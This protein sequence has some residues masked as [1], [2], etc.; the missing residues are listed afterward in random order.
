MQAAGLGITLTSAS[1]MLFAELSWVAKDLRQSEDR[2]HRIGQKDPVLIQH[3]VYDGSLDASMS[4]RL[5]QRMEMADQALDSQ[6]A[7]QE[8][9]MGLPE[10]HHVHAAQTAPPLTHE[11]HA[12]AHEALSILCG[13]L[14]QMNPVDGK[15]TRALFM[16]DGRGDLRDTQAALVL[17]LAMKYLQG[18]A[19]AGVA[20]GYFARVR[21]QSSP[22]S[23][24][25]LQSSNPEDGEGDSLPDSTTREPG[26]EEI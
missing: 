18:Q 14:Q 19:A 26:A 9:R 20:L 21:Q 7:E 23:L 22:D 8:T 16:A 11:E 3:L 17:Q 1:L 4:Q 10:D 2:I 6:N 24:P 5:I 15:I 25:T 13:E 12:A